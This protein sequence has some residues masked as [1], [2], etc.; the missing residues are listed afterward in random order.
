M[1]KYSIYSDRSL[2]MSCFPK[3]HML[4]RAS[5]P[6]IE[7]GS[8]HSVWT[9]L[10]WPWHL[11][12]K[13]LFL[14]KG[15]DLFGTMWVNV[16]ARCLIT[17]IAHHPI[18]FFSVRKK[19]SRTEVAVQ[20]YWTKIFIFCSSLQFVVI[21]IP[22]ANNCKWLNSET[23]YSLG[24]LTNDDKFAFL[25]WQAVEIAHALCAVPTSWSG[26][27]GLMWKQDALPI[28]C[29]YTSSCYFFLPWLSNLKHFEVNEIKDRNKWCAVH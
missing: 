10:Q 25:I 20:N 26:S 5:Y 22:I 8:E 28:I 1:Q 4:Q 18:F 9:R 27:T 24:I 17:I 16:S 11:R 29:H 19:R 6:V 13:T 21:F 23:L 2:N 14:F 3:I 7:T 15:W 12:G